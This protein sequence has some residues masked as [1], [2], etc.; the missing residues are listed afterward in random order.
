MADIRR[1]LH[2]GAANYRASVYLNGLLRGEHEGGFTPFNFDITEDVKSGENLLVV[3]VDNRRADDDVPT[4]MTD[5]HNYGGLTREVSLLRVPDVYVRSWQL[6]LGED[7]AHIE[8]WIE[9]VGLAAG[10]PIILRISELDIKQEFSVGE[11]GRAQVVIDA[12][13]GR[14]QAAK[15]AIT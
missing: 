13:R 5:W 3:K 11:D 8:G 1:L 7:G 9:A 12:V 14:S 15:P 6:G 10:E 2:F 4:P